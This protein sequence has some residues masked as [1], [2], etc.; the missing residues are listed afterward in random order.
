MKS[1]KQRAKQLS[2]MLLF[3]LGACLYGGGTPR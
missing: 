2:L 1:C 3:I